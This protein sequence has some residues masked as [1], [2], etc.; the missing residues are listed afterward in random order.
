MMSAYRIAAVARHNAALFAREPGLAISRIA[1][2]VMFVTL[3]R[4]LY[5]QAGG[6]AQAVAGSLVLFSLL[7]MSLVG[8]SIVI[9]RAW[10]TA[11]RLRATPARPIELVAGKAAPILALLLAQQGILIGY[12]VTV[13]GLR[14]ANYT[15]VVFAVLGWAVTLL[16]L[17][18]ALGALVRSHGQLTVMVDIGSIVLTGFAGALAPLSTLPGWARAV[19]PVSPGYWAMRAIGGALHGET[20][21]TLG[22]LA[23]LLAIG[24]LAA[25][26]AAL[27]IARGWGR[28]RFL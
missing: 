12:G 6:A 11:D 16:G 3:L 4:P 15:L 22:A 20:R 26:V 14:P 8:W 13:L 23:V 27:R 9:E 5:A 10:H 17:G 25:A 18:S 2:P 24:A 28:S 7:G 1:G 19:A 21:T